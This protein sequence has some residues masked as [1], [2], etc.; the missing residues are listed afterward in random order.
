MIFFKKLWH[1][2]VIYAKLKLEKKLWHLE[3]IYA[4]LKLAKK[5]WHLAIMSFH[6]LCV[7][8]A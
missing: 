3:V 4:K 5:L 1:L 8:H 7:V 6:L 2:E